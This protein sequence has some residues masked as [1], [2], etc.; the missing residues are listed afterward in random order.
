M[1]K[2]V[3]KCKLCA[4]TSRHPP[5]FWSLVQAENTEL[6]RFKVEEAQLTLGSFWIQKFKVGGLISSLKAELLWWQRARTCS[7]ILWVIWHLTWFWHVP[8]QFVL[9]N[10]VATGSSL[11]RSRNAVL[12]LLQSDQAKKIR[13]SERLREV[14]GGISFSSYYGYQHI[15]MFFAIYSTNIWFVHFRGF[16]C[17]TVHVLSVAI[18]QESEERLANAVQ[19]TERLQQS[20][21][22]ANEA[23]QSSVKSQNAKDE[24]YTNLLILGIHWEI[25]CKRFQCTQKINFN[26]FQLFEMHFCKRTVWNGCSK[27]FSSLEGRSTCRCKQKNGDKGTRKRYINGWLNIS[28][29]ESTIWRLWSIERQKRLST[30]PGHDLVKGLC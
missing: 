10:H 16:F 7:E 9:P 19:M 8:T 2:H 18:I 4:R 26:I 12:T 1:K 5:I 15:I 11:R 25:V 14:R 3:Y 23:L 24:Q 13:R 20:L 29:K 27:V 28:N 21:D 22:S 6:E 17:A 30:F